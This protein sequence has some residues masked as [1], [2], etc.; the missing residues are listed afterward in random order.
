MRDGG[1]PKAAA[2]QRGEMSKINENSSIAHRCI[3]AKILKITNETHDT[4][5][6]RLGSEFP[7][8]FKPGQFFMIGIE[9][10]NIL[11]TM[12]YSASSS[13]LKNYLEITV[14]YDP[15]EN[16][17]RVLFSKKVKDEILLEGPYGKFIF[18]D[19][20]CEKVIF[21]GAGS[22]VAPLRGI[23]HYILDK[24]L[25]VKNS[26]FFYYKTEKDIIYKEELERLKE[27][28]LNINTSLT[29]VNNGWKG[30]K[31]RVNK[32]HIRS[33]LEDNDNCLFYLCGPLDFIKRTMRI[34]ENNGIKS[35]KIRTETYG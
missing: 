26:L 6:F 22:G 15:D 31:G 24:K 11:E 4:K 28:G 32:E 34:L 18:E 12:A 17:S 29:R 3:R 20:S 30:L 16:F 8:S 23:L 9:I 27:E 1:R 21:L 19:D 5:T 35:E 25:A 2:L 33:V 14:K 13:P 10:D 7:I